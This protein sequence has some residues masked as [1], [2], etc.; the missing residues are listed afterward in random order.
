MAITFTELKERIED[1]ARAG[2][3]IAHLRFPGYG[4]MD[5]PLPLL[6]KVFR[7]IEANAACGNISELDR[8]AIA[9]LRTM[10]GD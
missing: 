3:N 1:T 9:V 4:F 7:E 6:R 10:V 5:Y 8:F 2:K